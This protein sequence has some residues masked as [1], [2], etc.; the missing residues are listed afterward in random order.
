MA[1]E[2]QK[3]INNNIINTSYSEHDAI[4]A[5]YIELEKGVQSMK[6]EGVYTIEE[7]WEEIDKI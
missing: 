4:H 3:I 2:A 5:L 7:A 1:P 6:N